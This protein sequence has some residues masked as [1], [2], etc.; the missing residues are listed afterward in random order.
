MHAKVVPSHPVSKRAGQSGAAAGQS[1]SGLRS[2]T[3]LGSDFAA[4]HRISD[5]VPDVHPQGVL[6][7]ITMHDNDGISAAC[8]RQH[9]S[10]EG[11]HFEADSCASSIQDRRVFML[12]CSILPLCRMSVRS[13]SATAPMQPVRQQSILYAN[14]GI[15]ELFCAQKR[16]RAGHR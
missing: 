7:M 3:C 2:G 5:K 13:S 14:E 4:L 11:T 1:L 15:L 10:N 6:G 12:R 8:G 9:E 16:S